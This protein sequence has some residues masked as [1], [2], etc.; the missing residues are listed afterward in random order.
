MGRGEWSLPA[1]IGLGLAM[2][3]MLALWLARSEYSSRWISRDQAADAALAS[4]FPM[5]QAVRAEDAA[6][7]LGNPVEL[8]GSGPT[9]CAYQS[10][11]QSFHS[12]LLQVSLVR[13]AAAA[14]ASDSASPA[15][16]PTQGFA[17]Q[18]VLGLGDEARLYSRR[19]G[20]SNR[21]LL[22]VRKSGQLLRLFVFTT[23]TGLHQERLVAIA[24]RALGRM[25]D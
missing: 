16:I 17:A 7:I 14:S 25:A 15:G 3:A 6:E 22:E 8:S 21:E 2:A 4:A 11:G 19:D 12:G 5:C 24:R 18:A 23:G 9:S 13:T 10:L 20:L 1:R